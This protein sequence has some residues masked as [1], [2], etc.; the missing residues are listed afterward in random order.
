MM[1]IINTCEK[2]GKSSMSDETSAILE[3]NFQA[4]IIAFFCPKCS[5]SNVMDFGDIKSALER[6]TQLP[7]LGGSRF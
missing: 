5:Y 4:K 3:V 1:K 2:C 7:R 6:K